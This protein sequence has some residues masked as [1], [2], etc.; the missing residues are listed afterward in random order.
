[1]RN[2]F[3]N[4]YTV[5]SEEMNMMH[6]GIPP[7]LVMFV[8]LA[9][10][11]VV[12]IWPVAWICRRVGFSPWLGILIMVPLANLLLLWFVAVAEWP[13]LPASRRVTP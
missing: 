2:R 11:A 5:A 1:L 3:K 7:L 9:L 13:N 12:L 4:G 8:V 6:L 10:S